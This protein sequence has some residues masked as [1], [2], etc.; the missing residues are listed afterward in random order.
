MILALIRF[1]DKKEKAFALSLLK[2]YC[3]KSLAWGE[4]I[5]DEITDKKSIPILNQ[6]LRKK[7]KNGDQLVISSFATLGYT[8][9]MVIDILKKLIESGITI[10]SASDKAFIGGKKDNL[11][12]EVRFLSLIKNIDDAVIKDRIRRGMAKKRKSGLRLGRPKGSVSSKMKLSGKEDEIRAHIRDKLSIS[13]MARI[14]KVN[15]ITVINFIERKK[16]RSK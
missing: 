15:R 16:L 6:K 13:D 3:V 8:T 5:E 1:R 10:H 2:R 14:L 11:R 12:Q 7:M 4:I 9:P